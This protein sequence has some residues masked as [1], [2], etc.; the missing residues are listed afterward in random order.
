MGCS[1]TEGELGPGSGP[2]V[3]TWLQGVLGQAALVASV[4]NGDTSTRPAPSTGKETVGLN[5]GTMDAGHPG[6]RMGTACP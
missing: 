5:P 1:L 6:G 2:S 3:S 4:N